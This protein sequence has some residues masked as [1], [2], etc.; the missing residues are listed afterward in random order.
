MS[1]R[2]EGGGTARHARIRGAGTGAGSS[3]GGLRAVA[4]LAL[5]LLVGMGSGL[6]LEAQEREGVTGRV[7]DAFTDAP[8]GNALVEVQWADGSRIGAGLTA[9]TSGDGRF[10]IGGVPEGSLL[11]RVQHLGYGV[12]IHPVRLQGAG[13]AAIRISLTQATIELAPVIV[14]AEAA[15]ELQQRASPASRNIITNE[16]I[17]QAAGSGVNLGDF[18]RR[19]VAGIYVRA[20]VG[21]GAAVCVEF[22]GAQRAGG[23]CRPPQVY[24]D[25]AVVPD[26]LIF[27]GQFSIA[28]LERIQVVPPAESL[29][30]GPDAGWGVILLETQR[31]GLRDDGIPVVQ[32]RTGPELAFDWSTET[33]SHPW[34]R[35]YGAAFVGNAVGLAAG[36]ALL[37]Y[38]MDVPERKIYRGEDHCGLAPLLG[39]GMAAAVLPPLG[40]SLAARLAG[41]TDRSQGRLM[42]SILYSLPM[43]VPGF[44]L[45]SMDAG[46]GVG[47]L[48]VA[49]AVMVLVGAPALN[50]LADR[51]ARDLR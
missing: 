45:A 11:V 1:N 19:E 18:L 16:R 12:H 32:R 46:S 2:Q 7:L 21:V 30:T 44:A 38:C 27:F 13:T 42:Q 22:R 33:E 4:G 50:T 34:M 51:R 14:E 47:G 39:S 49:G 28:A 20:N 41:T 9:L 43:F 48:E 31:G 25:G 8:I 40:G 23:A 26:P 17:Q 36:M 3:R 35:V 29:T 37:S 24:L 6:C 10:E 5:A 15:Q